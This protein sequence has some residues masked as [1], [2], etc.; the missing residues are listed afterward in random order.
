M[1]GILVTI[2]GPG[3]SGKTS[4]VAETAKYLQALRLPVFVTKQPSTLPLGE[5]VRANADTYFGVTLATLVAA[6]RHN[7][8]EAE[9][10]PHL[11]A[12][13]IVLCDR[14]LPSS[15]VLQVLDGVSAD[16]V[17]ALNPGV[18]VPDAAVF[19]RADA[20]TITERV[21]VRGAHDRFERAPNHAVRQLALYDK[22]VS[23]LVS[24]GWPVHTIECGTLASCEIAI[25]VAN[26]VIPLLHP[27][28]ARSTA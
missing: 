22:T 27:R 20:D 15:L 11:A 26:L 7:H 5:Y 2:D 16:M 14:Y 23:D 24:R 25:M 17:W 12:G 4:A 28:N 10:E 1:A 8:Q 21:R 9:I 13:D 18:R 6:D 19:L 3:G